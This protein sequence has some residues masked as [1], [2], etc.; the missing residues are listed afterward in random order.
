MD[1]FLVRKV[2][3]C[4]KKNLGWNLKAYIYR[5]WSRRWRKKLG[6]GQ[7]ATL[8]ALSEREYYLEP[9]GYDAG[10]EK[11]IIQNLIFAN[12]KEFFLAGIQQNVLDVSPKISCR[13][14]I[15]LISEPWHCLA[16]FR[17]CF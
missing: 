6:A 2:G 16:K 4:K 17:I 8:V 1:F 15:W 11:V 9:A 13:I 10:P 3:C 5:G 7:N 14:Q 12:L